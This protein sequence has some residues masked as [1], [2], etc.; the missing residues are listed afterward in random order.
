MPASLEA[1]LTAIVSLLRAMKK[2]SKNCFMGE[3]PCRAKE[4]Y[5]VVQTERSAQFLLS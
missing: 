2:V 4:N 5:G 1:L 3:I